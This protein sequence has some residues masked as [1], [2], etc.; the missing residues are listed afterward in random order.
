MGESPLS[1]SDHL[2]RIYSSF[3]QRADSPPEQEL[4]RI[5]ERARTK[6]LL[7][8]RDL[9][10]GSIGGPASYSD[11]LMWPQVHNLLQHLHGRPV[12]SSE[13][14]GFSSFM[15]DD[16]DQDLLFFL[17]H[18]QS[19][20]F[21]DFI[22]QSF[23]VPNPPND[24]GDSSSVIE[25]I[26]TIF[27]AE[28]LPYRLTDLT[29]VERAPYRNP[30]AAVGPPIPTPR[31]VRE[32]P[33]IVVVEEEVAFEEAV[34]PTLR[35]LAARPFSVADSE[36]RQALQQYRKG[37]F[38]ACLTSCG[39]SLESV[40][41]VICDARRWSYNERAALGDLLDLVISELGL[42]AVYA[43]K[44]KLLATMRNRM[45]SSHGGGKSAR[46][47]QQHYAQ[48]MVTT[49]AATIVFLVAEADGRN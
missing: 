1:I 19:A 39:S 46:V 40:V 3:S 34:Q 12:L 38:G 16:Q 8:Y 2:K 35:A 15:A 13:L 43:E 20:E 6:V 31:E 29:W 9:V 14:R 45:S 28:G 41:K 4:P 30:L 48:Y 22:E 44:F 11:A 5:Q 37:E 42:D 21:L 10:N 27:I 25:A 49:T 24:F 32:Y 36:F 18:C 33:K 23:A 7:L 47:P 17:S 26:N